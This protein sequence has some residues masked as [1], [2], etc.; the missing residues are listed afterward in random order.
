MSRDPDA[1]IPPPLRDRLRAEDA[2]EQD[3][4]EAVW[5]LLGTVDR[6]SSDDPDLSEAWAALRRRRPEVAPDAESPP[7]PS[8]GR[9]PAS[10]APRR[11]RTDRRPAR[12]DPSRRWGRWVGALA[13]LLL[14]AVGTVWAWRQPVTITAAPGQQRT[15]TLPDGSTAELNSGT[16]LTYRRGFRAWP[17]VDAAQRRLQLDGEAFFAVAADA[18]PF[19]VATANARVEVAGTRFNVRARTAVDST[20]TVTV[21]EGR[22]RVRPRG[23]SD[24]SVV[25]DEPGQTSRV[26]SERA[27]PSAPR[28]VDVDHVLAWRQDRFAV[29]EEPL[30]RVV[31]E[32]EQRYDTSIHLHESV[33]RTNAPLSL[34]Y[35][36]PKPLTVILRDLCTALDLNYR[37][38][39]RGYEIFAGPNSR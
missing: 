22:I 25:L 7:S 16:T 23:L 34:Y 36:S 8:N 1:P 10:E 26:T 24:R 15:V 17:L 30:V 27:A 35:P 14:V 38:T 3:D 37:P 33:T 20:T 4:L 19:V 29:R 32:L 9:A 31:H 18:R 13:I 5:A 12:P 28:S 21:A 6:S 11:P 39:S 2:E